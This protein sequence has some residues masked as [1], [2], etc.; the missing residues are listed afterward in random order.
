MDNA[1]N[2]SLRSTRIL[3]G[4]AAALAIAALALNAYKVL[5]GNPL[6]WGRILSP[7]GLLTWAVGNLLDP[8]RGMLYR[9]LFGLALVMLAVALVLVL[10]P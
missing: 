1:S 10:M 7:L 5:Q 9:V 8:R 3:W 2:P 6:E 4:M